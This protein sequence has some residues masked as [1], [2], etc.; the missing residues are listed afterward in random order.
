MREKYRLHYYFLLGALGGLTGWFVHALLYRGVES[1]TWLVLGKRGAFLGAFIG[2][3]IAAY[4]GFASRSFVRF[5]KFGAY[6]LLL[7]ALAGALALPS[8]QWAYCRL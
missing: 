3:A 4:E 5:L 6:G 7:G 2:V 8:A 1:Q